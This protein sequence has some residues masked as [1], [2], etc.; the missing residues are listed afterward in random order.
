LS[1]RDHA[2]GHIGWLEHSIAGVASSIEHAVFTEE[3]ARRPGWLQRVDP[4]AKVAMFLIAVI[5]ASAS[6]S[7]GVLIGLYA[8]ILLV[9]RASRLPFDFFVKRVWLGIPLF[10]GVVILPSIF[11]APGPRLFE[12]ALGPVHMGVTA[13]GMW[14]ALIFVMRVGVSVSLA[15]L[16][17]LTTPWADV[18]KSLHALKVPQVFV[19]VLSMTYRYIFLFLH[20]LN[21]MFE[22]RKSRVV[23]RLGGGEDRRWITR[24]MGALMSRSFKM[25]NDVYAAMLARGFTGEIRTY[26][27]YRMHA[28]DWQALAGTLVLAAL[29]VP[30]GRWLA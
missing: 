2:A 13:V 30:V 12:V 28:T 3:L 5:A 25:S 23:A 6:T 8:V 17:V 9:A 10:A 18:L 29:S 20:T 1:R 15:V 7:L 27:T 4:R 11:F 14:T 16:L 22:A 21:G 26:T 19:L 24:S